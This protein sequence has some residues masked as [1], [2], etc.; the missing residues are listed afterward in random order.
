MQIIKYLILGK[1]ANLSFLE[2][3][4]AKISRDYISIMK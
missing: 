2:V 3:I 4:L 1:I